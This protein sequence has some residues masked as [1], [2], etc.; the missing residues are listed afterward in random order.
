MPSLRI[1]VDFQHPI[2]YFRFDPV[3]GFGVGGADGYGFITLAEIEVYA[4]G[5]ADRV[6]PFYLAPLSVVVPDNLVIL[7]RGRKADCGKGRQ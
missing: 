1:H 4:S 2:F 7:S 3:P 6:K 5:N